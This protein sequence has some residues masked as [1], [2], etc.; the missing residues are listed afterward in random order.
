MCILG[1]TLT[2]I[3]H[4]A[5]RLSL[6]IFILNGLW[7]FFSFC[8]FVASDIAIHVNIIYSLHHKQCIKDGLLSWGLIFV[9]LINIS[10]V[11]KAEIKCAMSDLLNLQM[12]TV[13]RNMGWMSLFLR[14]PASLTMPSSSEFSRDRLWITDW[15]IRIPAWWVQICLSGHL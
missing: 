13:F 9:F 7:G 1:C 2:H 3:I 5:K 10:L 6:N 4:A 11:I 15:M 14:V 8:S 12:Q